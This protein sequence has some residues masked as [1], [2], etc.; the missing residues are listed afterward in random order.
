MPT[1]KI[2]ANAATV[3]TYRAICLTFSLGI[4]RILEAEIAM[5]EHSA[6]YSVFHSVRIGDF[7]ENPYR[8]CLTW[9]AK[10]QPERHFTLK[11]VNT[12]SLL[13][14]ATTLLDTF[15]TET[16]IF[17]FLLFPDA[18]GKGQKVSLQTLL[19]ADSQTAAVTDAAC[20]KARDLAAKP[21]AERVQ[22]LRDTF[23]L[24]FPWDETVENALTHYSRVRNTAIHDQGI[25]E[26]FLDESWHI[27][28]R[29]RT[30]EHHPT[31]LASDVPRHAA[32]TYQHIWSLISIAVLE[33]ILKTDLDSEVG[34][35]IRLRLQK[36]DYRFGLSHP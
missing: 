6:A 22:T 19:Q 18:M 23:G 27:A 30:C 34:K 32:E 16:S 31:A 11:Y 13:V 36:S 9:L 24:K 15:L 4:C 29:Q 28:H 21:F 26:I 35:M 3:E 12:I 10:I 25:F 1:R 33:Q 2:E 14:Y 5:V 20:Q 7:S 17:L 8:D